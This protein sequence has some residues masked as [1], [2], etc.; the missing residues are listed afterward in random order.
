MDTSPPSP[1]S[2]LS[3]ASLS[4]LSPYAYSACSDADRL[5][6][7]KNAKYL[8]TLVKKDSPSIEDLRRHIKYIKDPQ[9]TS[10]V[11]HM[12]SNRNYSAT[13]DFFQYGPF[14]VPPSCEIP[15]CIRIQYSQ[16]FCHLNKLLDK[17]QDCISEISPLKEEDLLFLLLR[18]F[19]HSSNATVYAEIRRPEDVQVYDS[20]IEEPLVGQLVQ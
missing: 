8:S 2:L 13:D 1:T 9:F 12:I 17:F 14:H 4:S 5:W 7:F 18:R 3:F 20:A 11:S 19:A 15:H 16:V 10:A 6:K